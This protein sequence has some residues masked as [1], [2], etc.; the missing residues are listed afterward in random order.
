MKMIKI[1]STLVVAVLLTACDPIGV[2]GGAKISYVDE[3]KVI[4]DSRVGKDFNRQVKSYREKAEKSLTRERKRLEREQ[5]SLE[6]QRATLSASAFQEKQVSFGQK[7]ERFQQ[8]A[9]EEQRKLQ[10]GAQDSLSEIT[11]VLEG[12]YTEVKDDGNIDILFRGT[13]VLD[14]DSSLDVTDKV[15]KILDDRLSS[16]KL[17]VPKE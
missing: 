16:I 7:V 14:G 17:E 6:K 2:G 4:R 9:Q 15:V 12:I 13:A 1:V 3:Q 11:G 8:K 5:R 10:A